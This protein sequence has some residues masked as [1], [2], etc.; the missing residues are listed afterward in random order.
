MDPLEV[1]KVS[2]DA[3]VQD[4]SGKPK[5]RPRFFAAAKRRLANAF[6]DQ[7]H[8]AS[9]VDASYRMRVL[10]A[11]AM[12]FVVLGH[13]NYQGSTGFALTEPMTFQGWFPYYSFHL[14][15]FLF[16]SGYFFRDLPRDRTCLLTLLRFI[17]KKAVNFLV[18]YYIFTGLSLLFG[19]WIRGQGFTFGDT[20]SLNAWL[21]GPWTR[22]YL[23]S[24]STPLWYLPA[25]FLTEIAFLLLRWIFR[26]LIRR[27]LPRELLLLAITLA[28]GVAAIYYKRPGKFSGTAMVCLRSVVMLFFMQLGVLYRRHLEKHDTLKSPWYFLIVFAAQL[29]LIVVSRNS[30]L[31]PGLYTLID[32]E[33]TGYDFFIGGLTGTM[34]WLRV[35]TIVASLPRR[36]RLVTYIG[37]NTKY[38]MALHIFSWFLFNTLQN[39]LFARSPKLLLLNGFSSHWYHSFLFYCNLTNPRMMVVY[40]LV[41][42]GLPLLAAALVHGLFR[43]L[44]LAGRG[45]RRRLPAVAGRR[46]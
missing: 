19:T 21:A 3:I 37:K 35:S 34:L 23:L 2:G 20:F 40:Y 29:A 6:L 18:P 1:C 26:W 44:R 27:S 14:A 28:A 12:S 15:V 43:L 41:G 32:F 11:L 4:A 10:S 30:K 16:I 9:S 22:T 25:L 13:M 17:V 46:A 45:L 8:P 38:I 33:K 39:E 7:D 42:M 31:S 5:G 24:F 36:S